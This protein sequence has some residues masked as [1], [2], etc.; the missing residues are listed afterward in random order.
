MLVRISVGIS[1]IPTQIFS[2]FP[3]FFQANTWLLPL[4]GH[5]RFLSNPFQ[6]IA[7]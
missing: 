2:C 5:Y 4:L 7:N 3:Q 1:A 6:F